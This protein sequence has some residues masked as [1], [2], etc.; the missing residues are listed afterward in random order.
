VLSSDNPEI[1]DSESYKCNLS[2]GLYVKSFG[3][4]FSFKLSSFGNG[5]VGIGAKA[6][7]LLVR[8]AFLGIFGSLATGGAPAAF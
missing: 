2:G 5:L 4:R 6:V 7:F 1:S 3:R 8:A